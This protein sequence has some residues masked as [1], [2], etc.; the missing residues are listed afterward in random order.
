MHRFSYFFVLVLTLSSVV[1]QARAQW[2]TLSGQ[3]VLGDAT[4]VPPK[5]VAL[6]AHRANADCAKCALVDESLLVHHENRGI[7]NV[8]IWAHKP[9]SVHPQY[10]KTAKDR[11]QIDNNKCR[12]Q[13]HAVTLRTGQTLRIGNRDAFGHNALIRMLKN[14][15]ENPIIPAGKF[16]DFSWN[17]SEIVPLKIGCSIHPW[18]QSVFLL[19]DHPYMALTD[20]N[21]RFELKQLPA[22]KLTLKVW[23][24]RVGFI[25]AAK[26]DGQKADW[27]KGRYLVD[28]G[29]GENTKHQYQIA[30]ELL[31]TKK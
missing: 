18:M 21:G 17:K 25:T 3:F 11:I 19:Q 9:G 4:T 14:R 8:V 27:K 13:P 10:D 24:E 31:T 6:V 5:A 16:V 1:P 30:A 22:G 20:E 29:D 26:V 12:Y 2:A 28:L 7:A 23:H 15:G